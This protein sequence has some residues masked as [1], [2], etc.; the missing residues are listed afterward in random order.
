MTQVVYL[1]A[2]LVFGLT[3]EEAS[4]KI[5]PTEVSTIEF[6]QFTEAARLS[7][8]LGKWAGW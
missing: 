6:L 4:E 7:L 8:T 1:L 3:R 5:D 2:M